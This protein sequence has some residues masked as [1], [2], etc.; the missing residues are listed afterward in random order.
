[1]RR[2]QAAN[3]EVSDRLESAMGTLKDMLPAMSG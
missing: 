2:L 1:V 3:D